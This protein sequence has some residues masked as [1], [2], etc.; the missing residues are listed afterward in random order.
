MLVNAANMLAQ[1]QGNCE[2]RAGGGGADA[3]LRDTCISPDQSLREATDFETAA[4]Y[5]PWLNKT[6]VWT[7]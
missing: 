1:G 5:P 6:H 2:A 4:P 7:P 3:A